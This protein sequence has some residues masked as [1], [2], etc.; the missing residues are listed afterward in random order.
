MKKISLLLLCSMTLF[1]EVAFALPSFARQTGQNCA[2]CHV[3]FPQLTPFGRQFKLSGYTLGAGNNTF[4]NLTDMILSS[5]G[6]TPETSS[7]STSDTSGN[8]AAHVAD[9]AN[10]T[11]SLWFPPISMMAVEGFTHTQASQDNAGTDLNTNNNFQFQTASVFYGGAIT[12]HIGAFA[13]G[14]YNAP[15]FGPAPE[16]K[17]SWDN[18]DIR[19]AD[20][21]EISNTHFIYGITVNNNPTVQDVWNTTPAWSFPYVASGLASTPSASPIISGSFSASVMGVGFYTYIDNLYY[22]EVSGYQTFTESSQKAL[23]IDPTETP[24]LFKDIAPYF[25]VAAEPNWG[26]HFLELGSF[27]MYA[28]IEPQPWDMPHIGTDSYFDIG[29][30]SQYQYI[31]SEYVLTLRN[32][33]ILEYQDLDASFDHG[34]AANQNNDLNTLSSQ[35]SFVYGQDFRLPLTLEYFYIWGSED[36]LLYADNGNFSPNSSGW[37]VELAYIPFGMNK[38]PLWP[39]FN[40]RLGVQYT[41]YNEFDGV[42]GF[43]SALDTEASDNNTLFIYVWLLI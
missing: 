27:G 39:W 26:N 14:T 17:F 16:F 12:D 20:T 36:S 6:K 11:K 40:A 38:A 31:A 2:S 33:V 7:V 18:T 9:Q 37:T 29:F 43:N 30:D 32:S 1:Q 41:W 3:D 5:V 10:N 42:T 28:N 35:A 21:G 13:Q 22:L 34:L 24:G 8:P 19:F 4:K 15:G 25:R 23:G